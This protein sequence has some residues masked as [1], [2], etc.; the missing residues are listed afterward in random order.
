MNNKYNMDTKYGDQLG[1]RTFEFAKNMPPSGLLQ[2][3]FPQTLYN[4]SQRTREKHIGEITGS[5]MNTSDIDIGMPM[6]SQCSDPRKKYVEEPK[7]YTDFDIFDESL[8]DNNQ[9][10]IS[11][12]DPNG[13]NISI[14]ESSNENLD[15]RDTQHNI[16][17]YEYCINI[18][19][20]HSLFLYDNIK[21]VMNG[22][23]C[24]PSYG[25]FSMFTGLYLASS[26]YTTNYIA[27]YFNFCDKHTMTEG[28]IEINKYM[29]KKNIEVTNF[30]IINGDKGIYNEKFINYISS[31]FT[32]IYVN[33]NDA[34][35][36]ANRINKIFYLKYG[37]MFDKMISTHHLTSNMSCIYLNINVINVI[38]SN[39]FDKIVKMDFMS[40]PSG[41][42]ES[43]PSTISVSQK[44]YMY[45]NGGT[46][47]YY[48]DDMIQLLEVP[49]GDI[50]VGFIKEK[51]SKLSFEITS[52]E[53]NVYISNMKK[54]K[55]GKLLIP[56]FK[57]TYRVRLNNIMKKTGLKHI[58]DHIDV[59]E[60]TH[61]NI[62]INDIIQNTYINFDCKLNSSIDN[63]KS[64]NK[65]NSNINFILN[66]PFTY[67]IRYGNLILVTGNLIN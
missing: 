64:G 34:T 67:Y 28:I 61:D 15:T 3:E 51:N 24:H 37:S 66:K 16:D 63:G 58:F 10:N 54:T 60:L 26:G 52:R 4:N 23:I 36:E 25:I 14:I 41:N 53:Y 49:Y 43:Q 13:G 38:W 6:R 5:N 17:P 27:S 42:I 9:V 45:K 29:N 57:Q 48:E 39:V 31:I 8:I 40:F 55:I 11:Y 12:Y 35:R 21:H 44:Y 19:N 2:A 62:K 56:K 32:P 47:D 65:N 7:R 46:F 33:H 59:P 20:N 22:N 1:D 18:S 50:S 30:L